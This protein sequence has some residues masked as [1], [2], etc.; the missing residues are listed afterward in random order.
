MR[1]VC[2]DVLRAAGYEVVAVATLADARAAI[3]AAAPDL[4][5]SELDL[6]DGPGIDLARSV[7]DDARG[8][9]HVRVVAMS[10]R[11]TRAAIEATLAAGYDAFLPKPFD[12]DDLVACLAR[13]IAA[14]QAARR[15][16]V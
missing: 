7:H 9:R 14:S 2:A 5:L 16:A 12:R 6:R 4:V 11:C 15:G 10:V 8:H 3:A 1:E 13:E